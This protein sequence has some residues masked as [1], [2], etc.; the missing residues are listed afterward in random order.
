MNVGI[1]ELGVD[2]KRYFTIPTDEIYK[3]IEKGEVRRRCVLMS[4]YWNIS[5]AVLPIS[6]V[7][8]FPISLTMLLFR[9]N[10]LVSRL[11]KMSRFNPDSY[12]KGV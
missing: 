3:R 1:P 11:N 12:A 8:V 9:R 6:L 4:P 10:T 2:F 7:A 5:V